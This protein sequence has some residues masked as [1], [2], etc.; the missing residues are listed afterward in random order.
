MPIYAKQ[1]GSDNQ[2]F[3]NRS[4]QIYANDGEGE[5][6]TSVAPIPNHVTPCNGCNQ[7]IEQGYLVYLGKKELKANQPYDYYCKDCMEKY[8]PKYILV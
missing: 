1:V 4:T 5:I 8:F 3:H 7:N 6:A 2:V